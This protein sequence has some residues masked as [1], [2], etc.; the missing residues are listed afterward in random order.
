MA[1]TCLSS[2]QGSE[3]VACES[4]LFNEQLCDK[5]T[6]SSQATSFGITVYKIY[7]RVGQL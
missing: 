1:K 4:L 2:I 5:N 7:Y 3:I 6:L